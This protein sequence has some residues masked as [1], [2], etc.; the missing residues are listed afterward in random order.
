MRMGLEP[1]CNSFADCCLTN[2]ATSSYCS[3]A[4]RS[5][6]FLKHLVRVPFQPM[7][8]RGIKLAEATG[9]EP[10]T[11]YQFYGWMENRTPATL[12]TQDNFQDCYPCQ[13]GVSNQLASKRLRNYLRKNRTRTHISNLTF[14]VLPITL[15]NFR[16]LMSVREGSWT[17]I[18]GSTIRG[19]NRYTTRT[20]L[21]AGFGPA[22]SAL[23]GQRS[24]VWT[25]STD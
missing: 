18:I 7:N 12:I 6:T 23:W 3:T 1:T 24:T 21:K 4:W 25:S 14:G 5:R 20:L 9:I 10:A 13:L 19:N 8:Q 15:S 17:P 22:T 2:L 16:F 11:F